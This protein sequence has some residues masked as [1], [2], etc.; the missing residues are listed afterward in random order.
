MDNFDFFMYG[1]RFRLALISH[2]S[3]SSWNI[4]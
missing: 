2:P 3:G 1:I 4:S